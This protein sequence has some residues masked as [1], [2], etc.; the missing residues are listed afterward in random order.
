M[1]ILLQLRILV[2]DHPFL[3]TFLPV[4]LRSP[5]TV[6]YNFDNYLEMMLAA[7]TTRPPSSLGR[8]FET[9]FDGY[10]PVRSKRGVIYHPNGYLPKSV[11]E[12]ASDR[13]VL[14][15]E[16][17]GDQLMDSI[18]GQYSSLAYHLSKNISLFIGLS[19]SDENLRYFLR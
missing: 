9:V 16:E 5:L 10:A 17:F 11:L 2:T 14:S 4:V 3:A 15:E 7:S 19:L 13:L 1:N 18:A 6:T 8:G 12:R